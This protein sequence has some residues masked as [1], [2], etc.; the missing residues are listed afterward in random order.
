MPSSFRTPVIAAFGVV[1]KSDPAKSWALEA[2]HGSELRI[3]LCAF[4]I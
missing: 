4:T 1:Y 2:M 3:Q